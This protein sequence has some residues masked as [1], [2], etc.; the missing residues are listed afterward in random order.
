MVR[1]KT[2]TGR[3]ASSTEKIYHAAK[4]KIGIFVA[5]TSIP[6]FGTPVKVSQVAVNFYLHHLDL[7]M[8]RSF[9]LGVQYVR[10]PAA[11]VTMTVH[12]ALF[13]P[14]FLLHSFKIVNRVNFFS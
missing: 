11:D 5:V 8:V 7:V 9:G 10:V 14:W 2:T 4:E 3:P 1:C 12:F 6:L 13:I